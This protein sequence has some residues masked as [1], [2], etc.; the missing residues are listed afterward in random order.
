MFGTSYKLGLL[1]PCSKDC[2]CPAVIVGAAAGTATSSRITDAIG[3]IWT[4]I[5]RC[6]KS[7]KAW[8]HLTGSAS[9]I[10]VT[11]GRSPVFRSL[12]AFHLFTNILDHC[13][14]LYICSSQWSSGFFIVSYYFAC[15][16]ESLLI[17]RSKN[18]RRS[19]DCRSHYGSRY[20]GFVGCPQLV[21]RCLC[22]NHL[23]RR[24]SR[25]LRSVVAQPSC[26]E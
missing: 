19:W 1:D 12:R 22:R 11:S 4:P 25:Y 20:W 8:I 15:C 10:L 18:E 6:R 24:L 5:A 3:I 9:M 14:P 21:L 13:M 2:G 7:T 23:V 17:L 16:Q 26:V